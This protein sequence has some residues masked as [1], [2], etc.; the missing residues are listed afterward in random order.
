MKVCDTSTLPDFIRY[1]HVV[2]QDKGGDH[3]SEDQHIVQIRI[4]QYDIDRFPQLEM[5][6]GVFLVYRKR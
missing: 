2:A 4:T 3:Y 6:D 1:L 5:I